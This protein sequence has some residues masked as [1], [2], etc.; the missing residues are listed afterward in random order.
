LNPFL[1]QLNCT[2]DGQFTHQQL[3]NTYFETESFTLMW[4][5]KLYNVQQLKELL[6]SSDV[7]KKDYSIERTILALFSKFNTSLFGKLRGKFAIVIWDKVNETLYGARDHFGIESLYYVE[8]NNRFYATN[9]KRKIKDMIHFRTTVDTRA[10]QHYFTFQY[11]PE[12]LTLI[13]NYYKLQAGHY[14]I[15]RTKEPLKI[16]AYFIPKFSKSDTKQDCKIDEIRQALVEAISERIPREKQIGTFLS[17]GI[18]STIITAIAQRINPNIKAY[19]IGFSEAGYSEVKLAARTAKSLGIEHQSIM[20]TP[21]KFIESLPAIVYHLEDPLAD[22]SAIPLY[23]GCQEVAAEVDI[24]LSGEGADEMFGGYEIYREHRSLKLFNYV[25]SLL[26]DSLLQLSKRMPTGTKGKSF[27]YRGLTPLK[28]RYLGNAKIFTEQEKSTLLHNYCPNHKSQDWTKELFDQVEHK[29]PTEQMQFIDWYTWLPGDILFKA[30]RLS[31]VSGISIRLPFVDRKIFDIASQLTVEDKI[32]R[33]HTKAILREAAKGIIPDHVL[34]EKKR[35]FPV[36]LKKWLRHD[37]Y[38]WANRQIKYAKTDQFINKNYALHLLREHS[39][40]KH[41]H[42]R[43]L[44]TIIIFNMWYE[45]VIEESNLLE[46]PWR[47]SL[48]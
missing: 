17:G 37:L 24:L 41:D 20:I 14:F 8:E 39:R 15:K 25:P 22:P 34:E 32:T 16:A 7:N 11:V 18:D 31:Q 21:E 48:H 45:M 27:L 38:I 12:P 5:G 36:P 4:Q 35:G 10:L 46:E 28:N 6:D 43:K 33:Q 2:T 1:C 42:S 23:I 9:F 29:H 26:Q 3:D 44:W 30:S 40:G 47:L 13:E 19:T